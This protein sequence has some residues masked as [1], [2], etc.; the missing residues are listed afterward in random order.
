MKKSTLKLM[1]LILTL[2]T[3]VSLCSINAAAY[4]RYPETEFDESI[5]PQYGYYAN[6]I[7]NNLNNLGDANM[8]NNISI[9]DA[10]M[11]LRAIAGLTE[12][13]D[14]QAF[15][16]DVNQDGKISIADAKQV[17]RVVAGL[18]CFRVNV[19]LKVGQEYVTDPMFD[20]G[21]YFWSCMV[22]WPD[23]G[24]DVVKCIDNKFPDDPEIAPEGCTS[25]QTYKFTANAPGIYEVTLYFAHL[26]KP[27]LD[28][29]REIS[30][31]VTINP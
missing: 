14:K 17:L 7:A 20:A 16:A 4:I 2:A 5:W 8:D 22:L 21:S 12:L 11:I 6:D 9:A 25:A 15:A 3:F 10:R 31:L 28:T 29:Y 1:A 24:L 26:G 13:D 18:D 19:D 30:Y 27:N 23:G